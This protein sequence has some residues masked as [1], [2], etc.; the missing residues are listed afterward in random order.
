MKM[1][2]YNKTFE[3]DNHG[4]DG[5]PGGGGCDDDTMCGSF[6]YLYTT[7]IARSCTLGSRQD[8]SMRARVASH[9]LTI[10]GFIFGSSLCH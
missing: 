7:I 1:I 3:N 9:H 4:L 5:A 2:I 6:P 10:Q 8:S